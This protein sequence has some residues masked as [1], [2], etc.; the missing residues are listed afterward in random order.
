L[1]RIFAAYVQVG[2]LERSL[3]FYRDGLGLEVDWKDDVLAVLRSP[4]DTAHALV[5]REVGGGARHAVG[6]AGVAR[7]GW[8]VTDSAD[9][10]SAEERLASHA[11]PY[12]RFHETDADRI[13]THDP[14][15]LSITHRAA[16]DV[17]LL[18]PLTAEPPMSVAAA[19]P[20]S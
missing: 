7:L 4:G 3:S 18:V 11:V 16:A 20:R 1:S 19:A 8:Q 5:I 14:D 13:V 9:L 2:D 15:G 12:Q 6:E 17:S 10:D